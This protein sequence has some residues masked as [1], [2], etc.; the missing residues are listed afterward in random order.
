MGTLNNIH[1]EAVSLKSKAVG[2]LLNCGR[3]FAVFLCEYLK[4]IA[5]LDGEKSD[6]A[7]YL[8]AL[9]IAHMQ[10]WLNR[11]NVE[12]QKRAFSPKEF[13]LCLGSCHFQIRV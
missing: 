4:A 9:F 11:C 5:V 10:T 7:C 6:A 1:V 3:V 13:V 2:R 12:G 8:W